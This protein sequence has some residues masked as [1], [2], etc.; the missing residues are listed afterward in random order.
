MESKIRKARTMQRKL[1]WQKFARRRQCLFKKAWELSKI[2]D[3]T[4][5]YLVIRKGEQHFTFNSSPSP[6]DSYSWPPTDKN[7]V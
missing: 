6:I 5:T 1:A 4:D 2:F 3:D 7:L